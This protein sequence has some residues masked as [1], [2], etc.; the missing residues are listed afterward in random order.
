MLAEKCVQYADVKARVLTTT[1]AD[2]RT[3]SAGYQSGTEHING[4][5]VSRFSNEPIDRNGFDHWAQHLLENPKDV[6]TEEFDQWLIKQGPYSPDLLQAISDARPDAFVFHPML[7]T[8]TSHGIFE[9]HAP[10]I[11]HPALHDEPL[12]YF[13][14]YRDVA[15]R[16]SLLAFSTRDEQRLA[17]S[18][19]GLTTHRQIVQ[20]FGID[21]V[22][23]VSDADFQA[24]LDRYGITSSN[25]AVVL[26]R[27]DSAKGADMCAEM[28]S[29]THNSLVGVDTLIFVGP[30]SLSSRVTSSKNIVLTGVVDDYEKAALISGARCLISPSV[31]ESFSL[32]V[33]EAMSAGVPVAVN[34]MCGATSEHVMRSGSGVMFESAAEFAA[35]V[36]LVSE[37]SDFRQR[38]IARGTSYVQDNYAWNKIIVDYCATITSMMS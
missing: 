32:V 10:S 21:P 13:P 6:T 7:S 24:T 31:T 37:D 19:W 26:G 2:E 36:S 18:L 9:T 15:R 30:I 4:V 35:G 25:Y 3:W 33:L 34:G 1:A 8:P 38:S 29:A 5:E 12:S 23:D 22:P 20:G 16:S 27:V 17:Q 28:F 14:S 11:L